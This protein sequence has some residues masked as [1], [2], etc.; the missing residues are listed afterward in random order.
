MPNIDAKITLRAVDAGDE[1][2]FQLKSNFSKGGA[3]Q[4]Q[5]QK[6]DKFIMQYKLQDPGLGLS[7]LPNPTDAF[8]V[9][10]TDCPK[11][12][13]SDVNFRPISVSQD[14]KTL[15]VENDNVDVSLY[16]YTLRFSDGSGRVVEFDP[17]I[18]NRNSGVQK[19]RTSLAVAVVV[20]A[21][22]LA[23]GVAIGTSL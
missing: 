14:G 1:I 5:G 8:W 20:G 11:S 23:V 7:F 6:G 13:S 22:A 10:R 21:V 3:L 9:S 2:I 12:A 17:I 19:S 18:D 16:Y 15:T 4:F